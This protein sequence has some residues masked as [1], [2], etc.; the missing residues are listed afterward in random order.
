[1]HTNMFVTYIQAAPEYPKIFQNTVLV[2]QIK[3]T[4]A[5]QNYMKEDHKVK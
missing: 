3:K 2:K 5:K 1:M 4:P